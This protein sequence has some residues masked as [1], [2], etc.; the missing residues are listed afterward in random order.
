V[1]ELAAHVARCLQVQNLVPPKARLVV[2][3]SGGLDSMVLLHVLCHLAQQLD[4]QLVVAHFN[5]QLRGRASHADEQFVVRSARRLGLRCLVERGDV[6][7]RQRSTGASIE[8]AARELRHAFLAAAA[9]AAGAAHVALGHHADDQIELLFLRLLRGAG[10]GLAGMRWVSASPV[11]PR[12]LLVRPLLDSPR[13]TLEA[14]A[15]AQRVRFREDATNTDSSIERNWIRATLLPQLHRRFGNRAR[16]SILQSMD[17]LGEEFEFL[18]TQARAWLTA[19]PRRRLPFH[20]LPA[21]LQRACVQIRLIDAGIVPEFHHIEQ[22]R[23]TP[24]QAGVCAEG[25]RLRLATDGT[26]VKEQLTQAPRFRA[27]RRELRLRGAKGSAALG[28]VRVQWQL[29]ATTRTR[30]FSLGS[31]T[32]RGPSGANSESFD[33][34][35]IGHAITLRHWQPGDRFQPLGLK[36]AAKLQDL[37][38]NAKI[39]RTTRHQL[40]L[41]TTKAGVI[42]WVEGLRPGHAFRVRPSTRRVLEW[43]WRRADPA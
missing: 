11:D 5:H 2:A 28:G 4:W 34:T 26:L 30:A 19:R 37:F 16:A 15:R 43:S 21:A 35:R 27:D 40:T 24:G 1:P 18:R 29:R 7:A 32:T 8:M 13:T 31:T 33:A 6:R 20:Q 12:V 38:T 17:I 14:Y 10:A 3:V 39:P 42:F 41:A 9:R 22:L 36:Q 25:W 23:L